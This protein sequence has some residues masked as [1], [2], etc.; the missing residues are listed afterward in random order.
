MGCWLGGFWGVEGLDK[1]ICWGFAGSKRTHRKVRDGWGN[2]PHATKK[3]HTRQTP[4]SMLVFSPKS[5]A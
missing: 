1:G 2:R 4:S 3:R 5:H